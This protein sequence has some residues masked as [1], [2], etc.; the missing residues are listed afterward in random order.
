MGS[1]WRRVVA[2]AFDAG[3]ALLLDDRWA[4][5]REDLARLWTDADLPTDPAEAF[6]GA[7]DIIAEQARW[8][9]ERADGARRDALAV[10][11]REIAET[12]GEEFVGEYAGDVAV[13]T[14][15]G[16][17]SIAA[18]VIGR[19]LRSEE[20]TSELQSRFDLVC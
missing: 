18:A 12:A 3:R 13:V 17:G 5:A 19:L 14:G 15:A 10:A 20:H 8:W 7:G 16:K 2:P 6:R 9:A 4:S 1:D 11:Y